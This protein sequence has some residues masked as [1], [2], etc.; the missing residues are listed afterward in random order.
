M[1]SIFGLLATAMTGLEFTLVDTYRVGFADHGLNTSTDLGVWAPTSNCKADGWFTLGHI[2]LSSYAEPN[3]T[4]TLLVRAGADDPA[5]LAVPTALT[6]NWSWRCRGRCRGAIMTGGLFTAVCPT[7]YSAL[8]SVGIYHTVGRGGS[9]TP[10]DF[11]RLRCVKSAYVTAGCGADDL[12]M[13]WNDDHSQSDSNGTVW[14]QPAVTIGATAGVVLPFLAGPSNT[15]HGKP[16]VSSI[17]RLDSESAAV[18]QVATPPV[19]VVPAGVHLGIGAD[20]SKM[21][22]Q[23]T[24]YLEPGGD[25]LIVQ[26]GTDPAKL[27]HSAS[28]SSFN[29]TSD[30]NRTWWNHLATMTPLAPGTV[31]YYRVGNL[32]PTA[33]A[34]E[35]KRRIARAPCVGAACTMRRR[36]RLQ[37]GATPAPTDDE[38]AAA[39]NTR[40]NGK[41]KDEGGDLRVHAIR[42]ARVRKINDDAAAFPS[43]NDAN[44][45]QVFH[46]RSQV[47]YK[48]IAADPSTWLPQKVRF[49]LFVPF[50]FHFHFHANPNPNPPHNL[51]R[52]PP[53][54]YLTFCRHRIL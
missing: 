22:V 16:A 40:V 2:A 34:A 54:P 35:E 23:W 6:L 50:P 32:N 33:H 53:R 37:G 38:D 27:I 21:N 18:V 26:W 46:F 45:S 41:D 51:T 25:H 29:F 8:G 36:R 5:A 52:S 9:P 3:Q 49:V 24:T 19:C 48:D 12:K 13:V 10:A 31:Y 17:L 42:V 14:A 28:G 4:K 7:G 43:A 15:L 44:F 20:S 39:A 11:P 1:M 30:P 47:T